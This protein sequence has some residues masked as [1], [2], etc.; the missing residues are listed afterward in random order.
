RKVLMSLG[1]DTKQY[2]WKE[3]R[4]TTASIMN[5]KG[6]PPL[7]IRDQLRHTSVKTTEGF[8]IGSDIEFQ[9]AQAERLALNSGKIVEIEDII[10]TGS[11]ASA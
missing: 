1:I 10:E 2:S 9:R 3:L 8:Y 11:I 7:A 5:L 6:S 4:H